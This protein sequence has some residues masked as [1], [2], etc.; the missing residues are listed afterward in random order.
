MENDSPDAAITFV[1]PPTEDEIV[2]LAIVASISFV[3][4]LIGFAV[5]VYATANVA[6]KT[7]LPG[8]L[9][10]LFSVFLL[11][12]FW[13]YEEYMCGS[14]ELA[15]GPVLQ[16]VSTVICALFAIVFSQ[17]LSRKCFQFIRSGKGGDYGR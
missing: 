13:A 4:A 10:V 3:V 7:N 12:L 1:R 16:L 17:G 8:R 2:V 15:F 5:V 9:S 11:P 14:L 6:A